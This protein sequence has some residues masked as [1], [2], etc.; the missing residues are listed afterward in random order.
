MRWIGLYSQLQMY[1]QAINTTLIWPCL[2][3]TGFAGHDVFFCRY[4]AMVGSK[5]LLVWQ[6]WHI[7]VSEIKIFTASRYLQNLT[8][9]DS[10]SV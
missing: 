4:G 2:H 8:H 1:T 9:S 7:W 5:C 3:Y 10:N 6:N